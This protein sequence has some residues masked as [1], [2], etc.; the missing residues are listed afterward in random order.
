MCIHDLV[1]RGEEH[2][3]R[4]AVLSLIFDVSFVPSFYANFDVLSHCVRKWKVDSFQLPRSAFV[5]FQKACLPK[6]LTTPES[7]FRINTS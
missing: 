5:V 1:T 2:K 6:A 7:A 4:N 3:A